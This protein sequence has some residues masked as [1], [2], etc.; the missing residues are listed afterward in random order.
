[1]SYGPFAVNY[2][3]AEVIDYTF[4][5]LIESLGILAALD[6]PIL[7]PWGFLLPLRPLVWAA[8]ATALLCVLSVMLLLSWIPGE[9]TG[10][11]RWLS[12]TS[13]CVRALFQQGENIKVVKRK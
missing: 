1:M 7:N 11:D 12:N 4:P 3:R 10:P 2:D 13:S 6:R 8:V 9:V 5:T